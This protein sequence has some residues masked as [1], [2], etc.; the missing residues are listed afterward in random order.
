[1]KR[2]IIIVCAL[3]V[4]QTASSQIQ[5]GINIKAGVGEMK[6]T[7]NEN[8]PFH[9]LN[10]IE[11]ELTTTWG[12][13]FYASKEIHKLLNVSAELEY[14]NIVGIENETFYVHS[15]DNG[16]ITKHTSKT[17][18]NAH[19][20]TLPLTLGLKISPK[21]TVGGGMSASYMLTNSTYS[22]YRVSEILNGVI[23]GGNDLNRF[24]VGLHTQAKIQLSEKFMLNGKASWG[25]INARTPET[26]DAF[27][28]YF[29]F[30]NSQDF[31]VKNRQFT[32]GLTYLF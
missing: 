7:E 28:T 2:L 19:Y 8:S 9:H 30:P 4:A 25:L 24:D 16:H 12:V 27:S 18:R 5:L 29:N 32:I 22:E 26:R 23:G 1:M 31:E 11:S 14:N 10:E 15:L 17:T 21:V 20:L 13:S 6:K 3:F